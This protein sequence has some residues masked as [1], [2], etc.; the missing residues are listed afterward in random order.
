MDILLYNK[1]IGINSVNLMSVQCVYIHSG[2]IQHHYVPHFRPCLFPSTPQN[3]NDELK[4]VEVPCQTGD[5]GT[6]G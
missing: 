5:N 2:D 3:Q 6:V 1:S 4:H